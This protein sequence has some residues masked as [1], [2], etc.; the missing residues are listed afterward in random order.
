MLALSRDLGVQYKTAFVLAHKMREA[1]AAEVKGVLRIGGEGR[2]AEIDGGY[3]GGYVKPAYLRENRCDR[4]LRQNQSGKR[5]C[6]IAS[7]MARRCHA[8][9]AP[10]VALSTLSAAGREGH[11]GLCRRER[12][13]EPAAWP[14]HHETDQPSGN[15]LARRCSHE[16]CGVIV[17][18]D[19]LGLDR[20]PSSPR[21][22]VSS[23]LRARECVAC[24]SS[25][26]PRTAS[27]LI[28]LSLWRCATSRTSIL[29]AIG[30]AV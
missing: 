25:A 1:M 18:E 4:R 16:Q 17:L 11:R 22:P 6:V 2:K 28:A 21:R 14:L 10:K 29:A 5:Q 27:R 26:R 9:S 20:A 23:P 12:C 7:A 15:L 19:A 3:F 30:S 24:G 13:V 8:S